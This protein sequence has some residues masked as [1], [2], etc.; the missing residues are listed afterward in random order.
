[1]SEENKSIIVDDRLNR[2]RELY[3]NVQVDTTDLTDSLLAQI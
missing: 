1:M 3:N 2:I